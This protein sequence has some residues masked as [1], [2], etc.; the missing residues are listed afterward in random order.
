MLGGVGHHSNGLAVL[1]AGR[2]VP[3]KR[4]A[5]FDFSCLDYVWWRGSAGVQS[6]CRPRVRRECVVCVAVHA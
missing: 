4:V 5:F 2:C 6:Y 1:M 3:G